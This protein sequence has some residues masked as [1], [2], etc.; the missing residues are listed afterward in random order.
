MPPA[1]KDHVPTHTDRRTLTRERSSGW[2]RCRTPRWHSGTTTPTNLLGILN[3]TRKI[4]PAQIPASFVSSRSPSLVCA[5]SPTKTLVPTLHEGGKGQRSQWGES[6]GFWG[7]EE[8][9]ETANLREDVWLA[10]VRAWK[11][12]EFAGAAGDSAIGAG[13]GVVGGK[14]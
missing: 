4:N 2:R 5:L 12:E 14:G 10:A 9:E 6:L 13:G 11:Q 8:R 3:Q 7:S 1:K